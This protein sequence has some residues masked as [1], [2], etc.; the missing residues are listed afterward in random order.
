[1]KQ[2]LLL[3]VLLAAVMWLPPA[4]VS[5]R[6]MPMQ[7]IQI[8]PVIRGPVAAV[9]THGTDFTLRRLHAATTDCATA[10]SSGSDSISGQVL[11]IGL[12]TLSLVPGPVGEISSFLSTIMT[13]LKPSDAAEKGKSIFNCISQFV[14]AAISSAL[15]EAELT[16]INHQVDQITAD[17]KYF[18]NNARTVTNTTK[19]SSTVSGATASS[20]LD[21]AGNLIVATAYENLLQ[22]S[23]DLHTVFTGATGVRNPGGDITAF[24]TFASTQSLPFLR[25]K[26]DNYYTIYGSDADEANRVT[27]IQVG[28]CQW[29]IGSEQCSSPQGPQDWNHIGLMHN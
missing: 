29:V 12:G 4:A 2:R 22:A 28:D 13:F 18:I 7:H 27:V 23:R 8:R 3:T 16:S 9:A 25:I 11:D 15:D 10:F 1:M 17:L 21:L 20:D 14:D 24:V 6:V 26:Y 19:L 5:A